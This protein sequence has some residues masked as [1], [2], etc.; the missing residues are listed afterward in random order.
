MLAKRFRPLSEFRGADTEGYK[1]L[2]FR[3]TALDD[4]R[5]V[6]SNLAGEFLVLDRTVLRQFVLHELKVDSPH[7]DDLKARHFLVDQDG[8]IAH[9]LLGLKYRTKLS[10]LAQFTG[11]HMFVVTLRCDHSCNY[12]QV[13]RQTED[14][15]AYDMSMETAHRAVEFMFRSPSSALKVEFQ[16]GESLLNFPVVQEIVEYAKSLNQAERRNLAFVLATNLSVLS[17]EILAYCERHDI[18]I[19][20]SLDGPADLH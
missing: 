10:R 8:A 15:S 14:K 20:T 18:L 4:R 9:Q 5:V 13:S 11:L 16:G 1:L 3:F 17:E 6:L 12:C 7:Y 2:P 19:S